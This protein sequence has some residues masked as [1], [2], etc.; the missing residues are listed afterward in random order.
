MDTTRR[1]A[2][3]HLHTLFSDGRD[4][5]HRVVELAKEAGLS[6]MAITD[7]DNT[8]AFDV[9]RPVAEQQGIELL[10]GIEMSAS[11]QGH[12]IHVLGL[13]IDRTHAGLV[14]HL[15]TQKT[16]R[17][18]R[19]KDMVGRLREAGVKIDAEEVLALAKDGTVGRPHVAHVLMKHGYI[20]SIPEAFTRYIGPKNPGF[21]SGSEYDPIEVIQLI[22]AAGG[23]PVLAHPIYVEDDALIDEFV[24]DGLVGLEVYHSGHTPEKVTHYER[25]ADRLS[26]LKTGGSDYHGTPKEGAPIGAVTV[27]YALVEA[28]KAW[29]QR[30]SSASCT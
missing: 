1:T 27:P 19:V 15:A 20:S 28:L 9:A 5:P 4:S 23:I 21:V 10:T 22:R 11:T 17:V 18:Q 30:Q 26:L 24:R 12:E 7:H 13:L 3:L 2:D 25:I 6:A 8:D 29:K 14:A 16:R